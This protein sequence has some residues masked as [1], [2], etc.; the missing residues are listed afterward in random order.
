MVED[1]E[2]PST[3]TEVFEAICPQ[4]IAMGMSLSEYWD[5]SPYLTQIYL[6]AYRLK[7]EMENEQAWLQ[8]LYI[9]AAFDIVLAN[10]F[11]KRGQKAANYIE[12]PIDLFPLSEREKRRREQIEANRI[13]KQF[14]AMARAQQARKKAKQGGE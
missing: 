12:K 6:K 14:E 1:E 4:Y 11:R 2:T 8:G 10:A 9:Y 13:A 7:R 5:G 3:Y